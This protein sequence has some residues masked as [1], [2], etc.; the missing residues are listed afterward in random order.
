MSAGR[1]WICWL[2]TVVLVGV[3]STGICFFMG[4]FNSSLQAMSLTVVSSQG[5][6]GDEFGQSGTARSDLILGN[7]RTIWAACDRQP[8]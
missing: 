8:G 1:V 6:E 7:Q 5:Y 4:S 3:S 2:C